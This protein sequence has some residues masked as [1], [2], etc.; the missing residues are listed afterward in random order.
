MGAEGFVIMQIGEPELDRVWEEAIAP[1]IDAAGLVP[2]RIDQ[3]NT[4]DLLKSEIVRF[5]ERAPIIVA[6]LTNE[7]PNCYLEIGYAMGLGKNASLILTA[8][9]DHLPASPKHKPGGPKVHF[10]LAGY[11]ILLWDRAQ[12]PAFRDALVKRIRR[13]LAIVTPSEKTSAAPV[14]D[15]WVT[16]HRD[17]AEPGLTSV[18]L[19]AAMEVV[20][21][22]ESRERRWSQKHLYEAARDSQVRT[23]GWPIGI[24]LDRVEYRPRPTS[25]G[26]VAEVAIKDSGIRENSYDYWALRN[27]GDFYLL[28][29]LFE[30]QRTEGAIFFNTRI[31][32]VAEALLYTARLYA[33]LE[34]AP[35]TRFNVRVRHSGIAN[36]VLRSSSARQL[37]L[38]YVT[39]ADEVVSEAAG[40]VGRIDVEIVELVK[41][42][43]MPLFLLFDFFE[44][45]DDVYADIVEKFVAGQVT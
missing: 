29:S 37:S 22:L 12:L 36:R 14:D 17:R 39:T 8:R 23:F 18:G 16:E 28:Q 38:E 21:A 44:L 3:H 15:R 20:V 9:D 31:V 2:R 7:R 42:L 30:D 25:D 27:N 32:R 6:D 45:S 26:I 34:V 4:G 10:D 33:R 41:K 13:R 24:F 19:Q 43:V 11:D 1:A 35:T 40:Q 5:I